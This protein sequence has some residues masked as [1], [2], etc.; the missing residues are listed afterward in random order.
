LKFNSPQLALG[1]LLIAWLV[2][3]APPLRTQIDKTLRTR[4][5]FEGRDADQRTALVDNP[6]FRVAQE[7]GIAVPPSGCVVVL[8]YAGPAAID[9]YQSRFAYFLYPRKVMVFDAVD[10][11]QDGCGYL[12]VFRDTAQNL[13]NEPFAGRW[14][15]ADLAQR[16]SGLEPV[17][18]GE[19]TRIYRVP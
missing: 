19:L 16:L 14:N 5:L 4:A 6:G 18:S 10:R 15:Q 2:L 3:A 13:V 8:A 11:T 9:Y 12:A 1:A 17:R 7:I